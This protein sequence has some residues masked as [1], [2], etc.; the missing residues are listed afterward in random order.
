MLGSKAS[1]AKLT[2]ITANPVVDYTLGAYF[3]K[4]AFARLC[5]PGAMCGS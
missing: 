1:A 3:V 2:E 4:L 5:V